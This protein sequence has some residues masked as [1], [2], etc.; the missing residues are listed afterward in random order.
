MKKLMA[1]SLV[2]LSLHTTSA[3][4]QGHGARAH[5]SSVPA[6]DQEMTFTDELVQGQL[7]RPDEP[8]VRGNRRTHGISLLRVRQHFVQEMLKTVENF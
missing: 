3:S 4:A 1:F 6:P 5:N 2:A 8:T 7:V